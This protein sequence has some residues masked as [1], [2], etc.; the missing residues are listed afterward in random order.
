MKVCV[1]LPP[2]TSTVFKNRRREA[3]GSATTDHG[4]PTVFLH[5]LLL[6]FYFF[7]RST[8]FFFKASSYDPVR[9]H[10]LPNHR[11][12]LR[13]HRVG[14]RFNFQHPWTSHT[15]PP[16]A[17]TVKLTLIHTYLLRKMKKAGKQHR[18]KWAADVALI[19]VAFERIAVYTHTSITPIR[20]RAWRLHMRNAPRWRKIQRHKEVAVHL[21]NWAEAA[22]DAGGSRQSHQPV[23]WLGTNLGPRRSLGEK[24]RTGLW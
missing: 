9:G 12:C 10:H 7:P 13:L 21:Q 23:P 4:P 17:G 19:V 22:D 6:S 15:K 18:K 5:Q 2:I 24:S 14:H 8:L 3:G 16:Y 20:I 11:L 1:S